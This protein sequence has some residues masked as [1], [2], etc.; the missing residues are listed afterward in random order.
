VTRAIPLPPSRIE[1]ASHVLA[2]AFFNDPLQCYTFPDPQQRARLSPA[3][4]AAIVRYGVLAGELW[5]TEGALNGVVIWS[6]PDREHNDEWLEQSGLSALPRVIGAGPHARFHEM[7]DHVEAL[8]SRDVTRPHWYAMVIGVDPSCQGQGIGTALL[9]PVMARADAAGVPCYLETCQ[10][11]N[12]PFYRK[13][14]FEVLLEAV[15]PKSGLPFW[16][17]LREPR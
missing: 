3:H 13:Q 12:V 6:S 14:G 15:E 9:Q 1:E 2:R 10:P 8:H 16:T 11:R 17:F 7:I 4:F 5:G